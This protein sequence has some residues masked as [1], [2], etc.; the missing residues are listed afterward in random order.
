MAIVN[1]LVR[2]MLGANRILSV[3]FRVSDIPTIQQQCGAN[4][5]LSVN[6]HVSDVH[7]ILQ[8]CGANRI[9][10]VYFC[11]QDVRM[12]SATVWSKSFLFSKFS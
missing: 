8:Q 12:H 1:G 7:T 10:L 4:R 5:I 11:E 3:Y 6:F 2:F 9:L